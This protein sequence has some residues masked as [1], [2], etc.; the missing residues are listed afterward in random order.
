M[1]CDVVSVRLWLPQ[2]KAPGVLVD[3]A[4][5]WWGGALDGDASGVPALRC[6]MRADS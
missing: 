2:T 5:G 3:A 6:G 1:A 4:G